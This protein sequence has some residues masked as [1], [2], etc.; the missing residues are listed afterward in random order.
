MQTKSDE[1]SFCSPSPKTTHP[2]RFLEDPNG[3]KLSLI[4]VG[5]G[6]AYK[7]EGDFEGEQYVEWYL[8]SLKVFP[9]AAIRLLTGATLGSLINEGSKPPRFLVT[10]A[11]ELHPSLLTI[12]DVLLVRVNAHCSPKLLGELFRWAKLA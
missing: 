5:S 11:G 1:G 7:R 2:S 9:P 8:P 10:R 6:Q 12:S 4:G 3:V